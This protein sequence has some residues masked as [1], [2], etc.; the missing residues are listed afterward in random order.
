MKKIILLLLVIISTISCSEFGFNFGDLFPKPE[1]PQDFILQDGVILLTETYGDYINIVDELT[2]NINNNIPDEYIPE[3]G[4]I[5]YCMKTKNS[6]YG[7]FG[8]VVNIEQG[9]DFS[10]YHTEV[11]DLTDIFKELHIN[12][13]VDIPDDMNYVVDSDGTQLDITHESNDVWD[14]I[15]A[16]PHDTSDENT[17]VNTSNNIGHTLGLGIENDLFKGNFYVGLSIT[18][19]I[20]I[21]EGALNDFS[22]EISRRSGIEGLLMVSNSSDNDGKIKLFEKTIM[23]PGALAVGPILLTTDLIAEAGFIVNGE[24]SLEGGMC[25]EFE[26]CTYKYSYNGGTPI[27]ENIPHDIED[28]KYFILSKFEAKADVGMYEGSA[29]EMALYHRNLLSLG[30]SAEAAFITSIDGEISFNSKD[31]LSINPSITIGPELKTGLYCHSKL[32]KLSGEEEKFGLF[33]THELSKFELK[34]FPEFFNSTSEYINGKLK[35]TTKLIKNNFVRTTEEGFALFK[36]GDDTIPIEHKKLEIS[37]T[38]ALEKF[39]SCSFDISNPEDYNTKPYVKADGKYFYLYDDKW[40]DLGLPSGILW[41]KYNVGANS[42]EEYGGYYAWGETE[43]KDSYTFENYMYAKDIMQG[44]NGIYHIY[45]DIGEDISGTIYDVASIKWGD[46]ARMPNYHNI[47]ELCNY[48]DY[49]LGE[50]NG[51]AGYYIIGPNKNRIF[52]PY[53]GRRCD[54]NLE[55]AGLV[56]LFRSSTRYTSEYRVS[57]YVLEVEIDEDELGVDR[58]THE[59]G[60]PVRPVKDK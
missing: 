34:I 47:T 12:T 55:N 8:R 4:E 58:F 53:A 24:V 49:E 60:I 46:G 13:S 48:C 3:Y 6:P 7:F 33:Q 2:I 39:G 42:P 40:V 56:G 44:E 14:R 26:N 41:A 51:I 18:V 30:V 54:D 29:L 28:N 37:S 16:S 15:T 20:D 50:V 1:E 5:I 11:V 27:A 21:T 22:Y 45:Q 57:S 36:N 32:F 52:L 17:R 10:T 9:T 25:Y 59:L 23:L 31:L 19:N 35:S 38:R 43:E